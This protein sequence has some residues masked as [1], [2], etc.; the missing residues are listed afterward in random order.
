[1]FPLLQELRDLEVELHHPG[2]RCSRERLEELLHAE[3]HEVGRSGRRYSR[4]MVINYL[5][6]QAADAAI[7]SFTFEMQLL[8]DGCML[9][10][11]QSA[12]RAADGTLKNHT[13]RSSVWVRN[14]GRWQIVYHQGTP[15][16]Q[17]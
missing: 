3:F 4:D 7:E 1:M 11:Y 17:Q 12:H 16:A 8:A 14:A 15:A 6:S 5:A 10:T 2:V 13:L 9:L